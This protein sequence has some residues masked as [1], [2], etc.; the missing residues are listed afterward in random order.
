MITQVMQGA[1]T[2]PLWLFM[3][4]KSD[5]GWSVKMCV[6]VCVLL[7]DGVPDMWSNCPRKHIQKHVPK[8][9]KP[10]LIQTSGLTRTAS[11]IR[12]TKNIEPSRNHSRTF[13]KTFDAKT[14]EEFCMQNVWGFIRAWLAPVLLL[15]WIW[16]QKAK[17]LKLYYRKMSAP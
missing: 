9:C 11:Q 8:Q 12:P 16:D 6:C 13:Q 17:P 7:R 2:T 4:S 1:S 3:T 14:I 15:D 10:I 5:C